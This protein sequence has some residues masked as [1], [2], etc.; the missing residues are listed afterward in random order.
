MPAGRVV[1]VGSANVDLVV[2]T[3]RLPHPGETVIGGTF[4]RHLGGKGANQAVAAARAGASVVFVGALGHDADGDESLAALA[5]EGVDVSLVERVDART[6]IAIIAVGADGENQIVVAP[7]ANALLA[8]AAASLA[9]LPPGP[10]VMLTCLEIPMPCVVAAVQAALR[11][12]MQP[13]VNPAPA[14]ALPHEVLAAGVIL[15]PNEEELLAMSGSGALDSGVGSLIEAG[16]RAVAVTL[17]AR[18]ALLAEGERRR[19]VQARP[20]EVIDATGAGD[21]FSGV[22]AAWLASGSDLDAVVDAATCA[23]GLTVSRPGARDGMPERSAIEAAL[24][25]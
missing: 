6:G 13:V 15:T 21:T 10:G 16:A 17:G 9:D 8:T 7:G 4:A 19:V 18:G 2:T 25:A 1:V 5:S 11:I 12:G 24:R 23:A 3:K 20:V 14:A 22:L